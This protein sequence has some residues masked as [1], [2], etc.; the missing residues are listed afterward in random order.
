MLGS[1]RTQWVVNSETIR[2]D[3][4]TLAAAAGCAAARLTAT[5]AA[6]TVTALSFSI[7]RLNTLAISATD[8]RCNAIPNKSFS[9]QGTKLIGAPNVL[10][11]STTTTMNANGIAIMQNLEWDTYALGVNDASYDLMGTIPLN[12]ITINPSSTQ[13]FQ[14][15][16][17]PAADPALLVTATDAATGAGIT[18]ASVAVSRS[19]FLKTQITGQTTVGQNDWSGG[20]YASQSGGIDSSIPN[21][22]Q[23]LANASSSYPTSTTASLISNTIDLGGSSSTLYSFSW[24]PA[25]QPPSTGGQSVK[26]QIAANNNNAT[27]N[28]VGPDGT[29]GSYF[30]ATPSSLPASLSGNRYIRYEVFMSTQDPTTS[31]TLTGVS[32][33]FSANCVP[34]AQTLFTGLAQGTYAVTVSAANYENNSTTVSVGGGFQSSTIQLV[35]Q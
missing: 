27:W 10:K 29:A 18:G 24:T 14:F 22:L 21:I 25:V 1:A 2:C 19:G 33:A 28:F 35:H 11:F 8:A 26:F 31:P 30:T 23:L 17:A 32:F 15:V 20:Q 6:Q 16:L 7:D 3:G 5:V 34:Q 9:I 12:P 4:A 13:S